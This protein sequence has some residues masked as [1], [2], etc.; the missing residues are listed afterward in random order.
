MSYL[1]RLPL[2]VTPEDKNVFN[3]FQ[4]DI[5][6]T[7]VYSNLINIK[8]L[9]IWVPE[10]D[11][12]REQEGKEDKEDKEDEKREYEKQ[13]RKRERED[14]EDEKQDEKEEKKDND[15][16]SYNEWV[17]DRLEKM[18]LNDE[19]HYYDEKDQKND[20]EEL[21]FQ[22]DLDWDIEKGRL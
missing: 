13:E 16:I 2:Y 17:D 4:Y 15:N 6:N 22:F 20:E 1:D 19:G 3:N 5:T 10:E 9:F 8:S 14:K 7:S 12:K 21:I 18:Y 11:E